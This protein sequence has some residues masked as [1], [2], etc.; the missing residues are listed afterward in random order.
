MNQYPVHRYDNTVHRYD[1]MPQLAGGGDYADQQLSPEEFLAHQKAVYLEALGVWCGSTQER[2]GDAVAAYNE[3]VGDLRQSRGHANDLSGYAQELGHGIA[4][5][6]EEVKSGVSEIIRQ[7]GQV[8]AAV[9]EYFDPHTWKEFQ[10]A[11]AQGYDAGSLKVQQIL[12]SAS[13]E[14]AREAMKLALD[15]STW[16]KVQKATAQG[17]DAGSLKVQQILGSASSEEAREAMKLALDS[18]TW[19]KVQVATAQGYDAG[20]L[21]V[22]QILGSASSEEAREAMKLALDSSTWE[23][24]Q[25]A[26]AQGLGADSITVQV[27]LG[28]ASSE[29]ARGIMRWSID[30]PYN[31]SAPKKLGQLG[32]Q[33]PVG[34]PRGAY[35]P[36]D[37][38]APNHAQL[39]TT[40]NPGQL[41]DTGA[42]NRGQ[43]GA[44]DAIVPHGWDFN[45]PHTSPNTQTAPSR[46]VKR[47]QEVLKTGGRIVLRPLDD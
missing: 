17:Y 39:P 40:Q 24:V 12:G 11:T 13:S 47:W 34:A 37:Q 8:F 27:I 25:V 38:V 36:Q 35:A 29:E 22:Q 19:E 21:K 10:K 45:A 9:A 4:G 20:S 41:I 18:S 28:S 46:P 43:V 2:Y 23:K 14:E 32:M 6:S 33:L 30:T 31:N 3:I 5:Y 26:T 15:S 16:E 1:N 7:G 42:P 44:K